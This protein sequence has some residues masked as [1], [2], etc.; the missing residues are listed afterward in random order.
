VAITIYHVI[1]TIVHNYQLRSWACIISSFVFYFLIQSNNN[2]LLRLL[3]HELTLTTFFFKYLKINHDILSPQTCICLFLF[4]QLIGKKD[5]VNLKTPLKRFHHCGLL[6]ISFI[7]FLV[8]INVFLVCEI[9]H[10]CKIPWRT[11]KSHKGIFF[12]KSQKM[13]N[14]LSWEHG[15]HNGWSKSIAT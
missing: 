1:I 6:N 7:D 12:F 3:A 13:S 10:E 11:V 5:W 8:L 15:S 14:F 4:L 9:L 2:S